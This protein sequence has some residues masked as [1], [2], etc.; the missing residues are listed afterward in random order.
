MRK[1]RVKALSNSPRNVARRA[2]HTRVKAIVTKADFLRTLLKEFGLE[3]RAFD[4]G[5]TA[6]NPIEGGRGWWDGSNMD[7]SAA[8]WKWLE[9]LLVE[10]RISRMQ[11]GYLN[12]LHSLS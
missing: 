6:V 11:G 3:L 8:E 9:P 5:V 1:I 4:P 12:E 7:F 2:E 10:L